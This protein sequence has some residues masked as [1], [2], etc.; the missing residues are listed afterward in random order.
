MPRGR[1]PT[2]TYLKLIKGTS[3]ASRGKRKQTPLDRS[4]AMPTPPAFLNAE[5]LAEWHDKFPVLFAAGLVTLTDRAV[6]AAY[7]VCLRAL[8]KRGRGLG[9][10]GTG[11]SD[12][13]GW[14]HRAQCQLPARQLKTRCSALPTGRWPMREI[15]G[16]ARVD[17]VF[18]RS[19]R[20][21]AR[22]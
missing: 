3:R 7:C 8:E 13:H 10:D 14:S 16:R 21:A 5:A 17:A 12:R 2:P 18:A 11:R 20:S 19:C 4:G 15:R 22:F 9:R 1:P 6:F